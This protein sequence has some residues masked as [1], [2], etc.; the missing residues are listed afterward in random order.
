MRDDG[1]G[2]VGDEGDGG[3][4][5][6][7]KMGEHDK[8]FTDTDE[9]LNHMERRIR[10]NNWEKSNDTTRKISGCITV[11]GLNLIVTQPKPRLQEYHRLLPK[12]WCIVQPNN[13]TRA[14]I[15]D[16]AD[17]FLLIFLLQ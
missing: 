7:S 17:H 9:K 15:I 8:Y 14:T 12:L 10:A 6:G 1:E 5:P 11:P 13:A 4:K 2:V 16:L 3:Y